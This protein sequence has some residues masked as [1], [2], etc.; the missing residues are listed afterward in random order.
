LE[1]NQKNKRVYLRRKS[2]KLQNYVIGGLFMA[3]SALGA[4]IYIEKNESDNN[5]LVSKN[6]ISEAYEYFSYN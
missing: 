4:Y 3:V 1:I 5:L 2:L 6:I